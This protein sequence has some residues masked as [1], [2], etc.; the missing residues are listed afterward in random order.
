MV[1]LS[2]GG[3]PVKPRKIKINGQVL[4]CT[5]TT[6]TATVGN[7]DPKDVAK[8]SAWFQ[9]YTA[10]L[11]YTQTDIFKQKKEEQQRLDN[12]YEQYEGDFG[13]ED[14]WR[15]AGEKISNRGLN[16]MDNLI[17]LGLEAHP[18]TF[19]VLRQAFLKAM[20]E[21][22]PDKGGTTEQAQEINKAFKALKTRFDNG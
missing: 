11:E 10:W 15:Q 14:Q 17:I 7:V 6:V 5:E 22:H 1:K 20:R 12:S 16:I 8:V 21:A 3:F 9:Q 19:K 2:P 13:N 4:E 18:Q